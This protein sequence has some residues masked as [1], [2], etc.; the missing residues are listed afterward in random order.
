[1]ALAEEI[2]S[3]S[4]LSG[5]RFSK[6]HRVVLALMPMKL[7]DELKLSQRDIDSC[8]RDGHTPLFWAIYRGDV[9]ATQTLLQFGA[10]PNQDESCI[11]WACS[12]KFEQ[13]DCLRLLLEHGASPN[14][15]DLDGF[16]ALHAAIIN[17]RTGDFLKLLLAYGADLEQRY[18]GDEPVLGGLTPLGLACLYGISTGTVQ[19]LLEQGCMIDCVDEKQRS[20]LHLAVAKSPAHRF[21]KDT[22]TIAGILLNAGHPLDI[23]DRSGNTAAHDAILQRDLSSLTVLM[24]NGANIVHPI[25]CGRSTNSFFRLAWVVERNNHT[26]LEFLLDHPN[27]D[28]RD[29]SDDEHKTI[30]HLFA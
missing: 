17:G 29:S 8:D 2:D 22:A 16:T 5:R 24:A 26:M 10:D 19:F 12:E 4:V 3:S 18:Q 25:S 20:P 14:G 15:V 1:M 9:A 6:L 30:L 21:T 13:P 23:T 28:I 7:Q 27:V 11:V